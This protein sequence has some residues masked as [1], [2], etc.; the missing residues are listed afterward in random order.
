MITSGK[1][2][3]AG[4]DTG[5]RI[6]RQRFKADQQQAIGALQRHAVLGRDLRRQRF[7][8]QRQEQTEGM[9]IVASQLRKLDGTANGQRCVR[10]LD[11]A[12]FFARVQ[13][14]HGAFS[15][16][17][18]HMRCRTARCGLA[19]FAQAL[20]DGDR[21]CIGPG[22]RRRDGLTAFDRLAQQAQ[23]A[24]RIER[25]RRPP[26]SVRLRVTAGVGEPVRQDAEI[27]GAIATTTAAF[28][29]R[30]HRCQ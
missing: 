1:Y 7:P 22:R 3:E 10:C 5:L 28:I 6:C 17:F 4:I 24:R 20:V 27:C 25:E 19:A 16:A 26:Q 8:Q 29:E 11:L 13:G 12:M 14:E 15:G 30:G 9:W 21:R 23:M 18:T 2:A